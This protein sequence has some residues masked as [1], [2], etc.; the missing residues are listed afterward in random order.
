MVKTFARK[1]INKVKVSCL[2]FFFFFSVF[3]FFSFFLSFFFFF[4]KIKVQL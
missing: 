1:V 4:F 3:H 2:G